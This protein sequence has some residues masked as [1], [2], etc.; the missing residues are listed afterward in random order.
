[1]W[2]QMTIIFH[3]FYDSS[4]REMID[5]CQR[6]WTCYLFS[7]LCGKVDELHLEMWS[8]LGLVV[9]RKSL[10]STRHSI[11]LSQSPPSLLHFFFLGR[12]MSDNIM[13]YFV[14]VT[15]ISVM[16]ERTESLINS[17]DRSATL[18]PHTQTCFH[19]FYHV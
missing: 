10:W 12:K 14:T 18:S 11:S 2:V 3:F 9:D 1:M 15:V 19:V 16:C 13:L 17:R 4:W 8:L 5:C 7:L 6:R